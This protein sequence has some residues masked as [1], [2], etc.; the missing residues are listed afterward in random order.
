ML[1]S[2]ASHMHALGGISSSAIDPSSLRLGITTAPLL[3][4]LE[5]RQPRRQ[6]HLGPNEVRKIL[7]GKGI[8]HTLPD[9]PLVLSAGGRPPANPFEEVSADRDV[10]RGSPGVDGLDV[11]LGRVDEG[12]ELGDGG[13]EGLERREGGRGV[14]LGS[15]EQVDWRSP[16]RCQLCQI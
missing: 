11:A 16:D 6:L 8:L 5:Q 7:D 10:G 3:A 12:R 13:G 9:T 15:D 14:W 4:L 2:A 1:Y